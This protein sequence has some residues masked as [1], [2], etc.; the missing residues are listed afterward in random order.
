MRS[1]ADH[2]YAELL[3]GAVLLGVNPAQCAAIGTLRSFCLIAALVAGAHALAGFY[4]LARLR[5]TGVPWTDENVLNLFN[6][7][8]RAAG[9][10]ARP[11]LLIAPAG[12]PSVFTA[13]SFRPA[14]FIAPAL[15]K[16]LDSEELRGVF[17]HEL[18]HVA[19]RDNFAARLF[20][21]TTSAS[22]LFVFP[23]LVLPFLFGHD[24]VHLGRVNSRIVILVTLVLLLLVRLFVW[25]P[26]M[27]AR[28]YSCDDAAVA[29]GVNPLDLAA[30]IG[31]TWRLQQA[32][33]GRTA[34][35]TGAHTLL[36]FDARVE[37]RIERLLD[38]RPPGAPWAAIRRMARL[39]AFVSLAG[40]ALFIVD[41]HIRSAGS[42]KPPLRW[43]Q[44]SPP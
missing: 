2:L 28:E 36:P 24:I 12:G 16:S 34:F 32:C 11:S 21:T 35:G 43:S 6:E 9:L 39:A 40:L 17:L 25:K 27:V 44:I 26:L 23:A 20:E 42:D 19:R 14:I 38:Y 7:C 33:G 1:L 29:A 31:A 5:S 22:V 8:V 4:K 3:E 30:A 13:G 18:A 15:V 41:F 10:R 37:R